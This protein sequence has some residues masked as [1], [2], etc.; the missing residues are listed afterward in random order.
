LPIQPNNES[1]NFIVRGEPNKTYQLIFT[2]LLGQELLSKQIH[3]TSSE[4]IINLYENVFSTG[5]YYV[6][7]LGTNKRIT[8]PFVFNRQ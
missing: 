6:T 3:L 8:K 4:E 1:Q 5:M 2:N 7:M